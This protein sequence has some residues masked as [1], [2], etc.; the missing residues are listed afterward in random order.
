MTSS[1]DNTAQ[2]EDITYRCS[3]SEEIFTRASR[4]FPEKF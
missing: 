1:S 4:F 3:R 2:Q